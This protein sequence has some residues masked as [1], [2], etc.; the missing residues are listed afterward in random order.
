MKFA[1]ISVERALFP[2][3]VLCSLLAVTRQGFYAYLRRGTSAR[4]QSDA[5][6][7]VRVEEAFEK[8]RGTY[9]SPRVHAALQRNG[10]H[11]SKRRVERVMRGL[12]L[13]A[14]RPKRFRVTTQ[15]DPTHTPAA[16]VL[17]RDFI[18]SR[19]DERWV[20]DITYIWTDEGW[21]YL[22]TVIDL[23]SRRVVGWSL[24]AD[25]STRLPLD[26]L[27]MALRERN[28]V[29]GRL[30]HHTDRGCQYTSA[31]YRAVLRE[32]GIEVSMSRRGNCWDNAVAESFFATFKKELIHRQRWPSR[33]ELRNAVFDCIHVFYNRQRT[34]SAL[35]YRTPLET[36][37]A[38][39]RLAA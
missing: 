11:I 22:A 33:L 9:G 38:Y 18:A 19:P 6:L 25:L 10:E 24:S 28:V 36:E 14:R 35:G 16:N 5:E 7:G 12:G 37:Q 17:G 23:F 30:L 39:N 31:D 27:S 15:A 13:S 29:P 21:A 2:V 4:V 3:S 34:H 20:G 26:A 1:F 8:S 32:R